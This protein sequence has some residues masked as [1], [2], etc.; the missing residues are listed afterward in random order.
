MRPQTTRRATGTGKGS[1]ATAARSLEVNAE[2][3]VGWLVPTAT[4]RTSVVP[5]WPPGPTAVI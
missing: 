1:A 3:R 2:A 4:I 5:V